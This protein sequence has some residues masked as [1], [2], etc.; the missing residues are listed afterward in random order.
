[1]GSIEA[2]HLKDEGLEFKDLPPFPDDVPTAPLLRIS[3][4]KLLDGEPAEEERLWRACCDLGFFY[5]DCRTDNAINPTPSSDG[6]Q[7]MDGNNLLSSTDSLFSLAQKVFD[8]PVEEKVKYDMMGEGSYFG[9]KGY[10]AGVIDRAGTKDRNEFWNVSKDDVLGLSERL[11][12]PEVLIR[13]ET[14]DLVKRFMV[15][16]HGIVK[17][18]LRALEG[19]L[20]LSGGGLEGLHRM[21]ERSGDQM[22]WVK[23][24]PQKVEDRRAAL[25]EHTDF[26]SVTVLF[27]RL[28]GLQVLPPA[29]DGEKEEWAYV[30]PL[31]GH[32]V[33]NLG[34]AMVKFTAGILRSNLHRVVN[35]PGAQQD[36]TRYSLV[37]FNRPEDNVILK[38]LD[39]SELIDAKRKENPSIDEGEP[40]TAKQ[41]ILNR[42]MGRRAGG[43]WSKGQGTDQERIEKRDGGV[44]AST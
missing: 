5:L 3:L 31:K 1:M 29:R 23:S 34:D 25:G 11:R 17:V 41:W 26:G 43:D 27:N 37:Y 40:I 20:G 36:S 28:G 42:A 10:G 44:A 22:R 7:E 4:K 9:Y 33:V 2:Q 19:K 8:L 13:D 14:R 21:E 24:P 32:C 35:P 30:K 16:S 15:G 12:N 39:G 38:V 18:I 6:D